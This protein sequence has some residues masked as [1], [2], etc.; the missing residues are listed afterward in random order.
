MKNV[1]AIAA[2][3]SNGLGFGHNA[4]PDDP[5]AISKSRNME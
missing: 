2:G 4:R 3:I 1:M 5:M